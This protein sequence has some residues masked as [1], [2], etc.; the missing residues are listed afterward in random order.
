MEC[1]YY[2]LN[3][4]LF[5]EAVDIIY[6]ISSSFSSNSEAFASE[7]LEKLEEIYVDQVQVIICN[8]SLQS[9][10]LNRSYFNSDRTYQRFVLSLMKTLQSDSLIIFTTI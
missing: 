7:L 5:N 4:K 10:T 3:S 2:I 9:T 8:L 6:V 1:L